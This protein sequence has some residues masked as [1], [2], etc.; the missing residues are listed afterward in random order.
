MLVEAISYRLS[1]HTTAD[2]ASRYREQE[3]VDN[4]WKNEPIKR[5]QS[6]MHQQGYWDKKAEACLQDDCQTLIEKSVQAYQKIEAE[7]P[8]AMFDYLYESW[9]ENL[10][11]QVDACSEKFMRNRDGGRL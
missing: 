10:D 9:P 1:D 4:A 8:E 2:D 5:L 6:Y 7:Q 11:D 3:V